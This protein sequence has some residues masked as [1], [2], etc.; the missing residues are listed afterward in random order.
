MN[1]RQMSCERRKL[2]GIQ[3]LKVDWRLTYNHSRFGF[4]RLLDGIATMTDM[5]DFR[6]ISSRTALPTLVAGSLMTALFAAT[7]A[8]CGVSVPTQDV[9]KTVAPELANPKPSGPPPIP[10]GGIGLPP[11][12]VLDAP[13]P[14]LDQ[15]PIITVPDENPSP[16]HDSGASIFIESWD[17]VQKRVS[18][19]G[20]TVVDLWSLSCAPCLAEFPGLVR[21]QREGLPQVQ[22]LAVSVDFDGRKTRPPESYRD[23]VQSFIASVDAGKITTVLC[24]TAMDEV[25]EASDVV[26][27]PSVLIYQDGQLIKKFTD[28]GETIGFTYEKDIDPFVRKLV[29]R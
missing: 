19:K 8:G 1:R 9:E 26:S 18:T 4:H 13:L 20:I 29:Q 25:L 27:I 2:K 24:S 3:S 10:E 6:L 17:S 15:T 21:L 5:Q 11:Q 7:F 28:S 16:A 22:C 12:E 23:Q 14:E